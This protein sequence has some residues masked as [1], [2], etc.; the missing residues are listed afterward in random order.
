MSGFI[1]EIRRRNVVK[2]AI[3]YLIAGWVTMQIVDVMFPALNLP[4]WL[5]RAVAAL[6]LLG[7]PFALI[8][9]WA[10]E[11]TPEG[12]KR[13]KDVDRSQSI[14]PKTGQKL[15]R[16][17]FII[18]TIAVGFLLLD[19]FVLSRSAP[20]DTPIQ[21][22]TEVIPSIA[23]LPFVNMSGKGSTYMKIFEANREIISDPNKIYP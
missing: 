7:F 15:N 5:T 1:K 6:L 9:A 21:A 10:F 20:V 13:E 18:L 19:K 11:M 2:V 3:V 8:L 16:A 12:I 17:A 4:D 14:A 23:V 22:S